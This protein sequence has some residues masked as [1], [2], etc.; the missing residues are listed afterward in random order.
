M[1]NLSLNK[2][3]ISNFIEIILGENSQKILKGNIN[4][5][6]YLAIWAEPLRKSYHTGRKNYVL[7]WSIIARSLGLLSRISKI[8]L[9][10]GQIK[11]PREGKDRF[12]RTSKGPM[13]GWY[14]HLTKT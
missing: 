10:W 11:N 2:N 9:P 8:C 1:I 6:F 4:P 5:T 14:W 3:Y 13:T 7:A 12:G